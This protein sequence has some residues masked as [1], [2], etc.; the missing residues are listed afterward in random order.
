MTTMEARTVV[1]LDLYATYFAFKEG[2]VFLK[3]IVTP[4]WLQHHYELL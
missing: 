3:G 1:V 4:T 2:P